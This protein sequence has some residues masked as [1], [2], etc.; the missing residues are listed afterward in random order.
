MNVFYKTSCLPTHLT[1]ALKLL[2]HKDFLEITS[3]VLDLTPQLHTA[4]GD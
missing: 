1:T 3:L 4:I 2:H